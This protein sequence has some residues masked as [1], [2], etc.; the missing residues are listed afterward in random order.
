MNRADDAEALRPAGLVLV[1]RVAG[2]FG[3]RG[4]VRIA[5]YAAEPLALLAYRDLVDAAGAPVLSLEG[6]RLA[7]PGE[8]VARARGVASK[9]AADALRGVR[10][11]VPRS[12]LPEPEEDE[13]Y[14]HDLIGL[15]ART[16][17]GEPL[18]RIK[19]VLDHGAGDILELD[20]GA[21]RPTRLLPF[22]RE[23]VPELRLADGWLA[24]VPP[25]ETGETEPA[26]NS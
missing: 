3:V 1:G 7:R 19:A 10:L 8:I 2:A 15:E 12:A 18:G 9:E 5:S 4:E 14:L 24:V 23:V 22:T 16:P 13:F 25:V 21:G 6:G 26:T 20:P 17:G 11:H